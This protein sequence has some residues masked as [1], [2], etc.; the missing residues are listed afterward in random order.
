MNQKLVISGIVVAIVIISVAVLISL[1][2]E[3]GTTTQNEIPELLSNIT[4]VNVSQKGAGEII[5]TTGNSI[6]ETFVYSGDL[7]SVDEKNR[8]IYKEGYF[9]LKPESP[10]KISIL[11]NDA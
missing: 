7:I 11:S 6:F 5:Y 4:P 9:L 8:N 2:N 3:N 10:L 1:K